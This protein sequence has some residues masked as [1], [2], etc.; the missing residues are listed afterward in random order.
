M[1][2]MTCR[3]TDDKAARVQ[4]FSAELRVD[5]TRGFLILHSEQLILYKSVSR[6]DIDISVRI[7]L[8]PPGFLCSFR[9]G[10]VLGPP[11]RKAISH[12]LFLFPP[13]TSFLIICTDA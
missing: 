10:L 7:L 5:E 12:P 2:R 4:L 11:L 13:M 1:L 3:L 9:L 8:V 6:E